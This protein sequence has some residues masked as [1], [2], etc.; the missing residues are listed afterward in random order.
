MSNLARA[1]APLSSAHDDSSPVIQALRTTPFLRDLAQSVVDQLGEISK[2]VLIAE[3]LEV[4][5]QGELADQLYIV[6]EGQLVTSMTAAD[7]TSAVVEVIHVGGII[8]LATLL[9][10]L[11]RLVSARTIKPC[12]LLA[13]EAQGL[14]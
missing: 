12:R 2:I 11:P 4:F 3:G 6:L 1:S 13:I 10:R 5:R 9:A 7:G 14:L 8:G